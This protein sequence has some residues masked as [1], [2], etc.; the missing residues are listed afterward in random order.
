MTMAIKFFEKCQLSLNQTTT[1]AMLTNNATDMY[2]NKA[3]K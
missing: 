2:K 3:Q 1:Y